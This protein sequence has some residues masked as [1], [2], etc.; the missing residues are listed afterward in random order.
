ML[1]HGARACSISAIDSECKLVGD[2][3]TIMKLHAD[4]LALLMHDA[5]VCR[6]CV[7]DTDG[8]LVGVVS[9][10]DI[11]RATMANFQY[12]MDRQDA[13]EGL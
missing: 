3:S 5:R 2:S 9:R 11:M 10:G 13:K 1:T 12:Y 4:S 8:K 6:I 7:I